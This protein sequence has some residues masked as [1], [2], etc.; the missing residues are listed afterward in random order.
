MFRINY[1]KNIFIFSYTLTQKSATNKEEKV[2]DVEDLVSNGCNGSAQEI[3]D[4]TRF[5]ITK[6]SEE[7]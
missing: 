5:A 3:L 4:K 2:T 6:N 7:I 1:C